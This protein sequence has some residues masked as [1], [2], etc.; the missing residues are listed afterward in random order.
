METIEELQAQIATM[1]KAARHTRIHHRDDMADQ[2]AR[3]ERVVDNAILDL[4]NSLVAMSRGPHKMPTAIYLIESA[5]H[6]LTNL[7]NH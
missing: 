4:R 3:S 7:T 6:D 2:K 1:Q 5:L